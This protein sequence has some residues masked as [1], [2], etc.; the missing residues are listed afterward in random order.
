MGD[1]RKHRFILVSA[2]LAISLSISLLQAKAQKDSI[3]LHRWH[4]QVLP[5]IMRSV[6]TDWSGG[7]VLSST[8]HLK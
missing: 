7:A 2:L 4:S 1:W 8:F 3:P 6:E 5:V